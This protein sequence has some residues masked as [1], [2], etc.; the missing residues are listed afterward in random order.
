M[1]ILVHIISQKRDIERY[2]EPHWTIT[3]LKERLELITGIPVAAQQLNLSS[4]K[5]IID[6]D[7]SD[8]RN[9]TEIDETNTFDNPSE[10]VTHFQLSDEAYA[11]LPNTFAK[12]KEMHLATT[13]DKQILSKINLARQKIHQKGICINERCMIQGADQTR[14]GWVRFI[15]NVKGLPEGIWVGVEY[16]EPVGKN[17]GSFQGIQYFT[18]DQNHGSF[19]HPNKIEMCPPSPPIDIN[20]DEEI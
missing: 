4:D 7:I 3:H 13:S 8:I 2:I 1:G 5:A 14:Y 11:A 9:K 15:G 6:T 17:D 19:L 18:A 10:D 16:D 20:S 12:W